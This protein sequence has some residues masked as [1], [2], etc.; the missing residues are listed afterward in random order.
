[1]KAI[2]ATE[3]TYALFNKFTIMKFSLLKSKTCMLL[4]FIYLE[5][6]NQDACDKVISPVL[7]TL[8]KETKKLEFKDDYMFQYEVDKLLDMLLTHG[9]NVQLT[10]VKNLHIKLNVHELTNRLSEK[11]EAN[12]YKLK[13]FYENLKTRIMA[14]GK[15]DQANNVLYQKYMDTFH[16]VEK[17][18]NESLANKKLAWRTVFD[19]Y[20]ANIITFQFKIRTLVALRHT[21]IFAAIND[22][23]LDYINK[24]IKL[25]GE[26]MGTHILPVL[27]QFQKQF[28]MEGLQ[29]KPLILGQFSWTYSEFFQ[30][31]IDQFYILIVL[32][33]ILEFDYKNPQKTL[34]E[35]Q[36]TKLYT[37]TISLLT[38]LSNSSA[39]SPV[40]NIQL[41]SNVF[42][43]TKEQSHPGYDIELL[44][45]VH[46]HFLTT[47]ENNKEIFESELKLEVSIA[48]KNADLLILQVENERANAKKTKKRRPPS[49]VS[50]IVEE[51][52]DSPDESYEEEFE[53]IPVNP[54]QE[55]MDNGLLMLKRKDYANAIEYFLKAKNEASWQNDNYQ[56]LN[57][58]DALTVAYSF[59]LQQD[60]DKILI[61]LNKRLQTMRPLSDDMQDELERLGY[62][63][64][65]RYS[66]LCVLY[67]DFLQAIEYEKISS[68]AHQII[69]EISEGKE[70]IYS[71]ICSI[72]R[73]IEIVDK[74][75]GELEKK[76][77]NER[78]LYH[79]KL[80]KELITCA[81][82]PSKYIPN[83]LI[84]IG[85]IKLA[86]YREKQ[87]DGTGVNQLSLLQIG[88]EFIQSQEKIAD[89]TQEEITALG[90]IKFSQLGRL[91]EDN[92]SGQSIFTRE[93]Q[94]FNQLQLIFKDISQ[95][96]S[97]TLVNDLEKTPVQQ[98]SVNLTESV[99]ALFLS[100][101]EASYEHYLVGS[102]AINILLAHW[103]QPP[104]Q[105]LDF[106]FV[107]TYV[108]NRA[109]LRLKF[110]QSTMRTNLF[111]GTLFGQK[112]DLLCLNP[113]N[114]WLMKSLLSR[115]FTIAALAVGYD[116]ATNQGLI[117]DPTG[118]GFEDLQE[119][120]IKTIG[121]PLFRLQ[122]DPTIA[123]AVIKYE[124]LGFKIDSTVTNAMFQLTT[125][126]P[127][128]KAHLN[129]LLTKL[130]Q[131]F[132]EFDVL[133]LLIKYKLLNT[134]FNTNHQSDEG[135]TLFELKKTISLTAPGLFINPCGFFS[136]STSTKNHAE[137]EVKT[138]S[139]T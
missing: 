121:N 53:D 113:E 101:N 5:S 132:N 84:A 65:E 117:I 126:K 61:T 73:K 34:L 98:I 9:E 46:A 28:N 57:V 31:F 80:G 124:L 56:Q 76:K 123:L 48:Q 63:V 23:D 114:N 129:A 13:W 54:I 130:L 27:S 60:L 47:E 7:M 26:L 43:N 134:L 94:L 11:C 64:D 106:D 127:L 6:G 19:Y 103:N 38:F 21:T 109:M 78:S 119:R 24:Y 89:Y 137:K 49:P 111:Y 72:K 33:D 95:H 85:R 120:C 118:S 71:L 79:S 44:K 75:N 2:L 69:Q 30:L 131:Q 55:N 87:N 67:Q 105:A 40:L 102:S 32:N 16:A 107:T 139:F 15:H 4:G 96:A 125:T 136:S 66:E 74:K 108:D 10:P 68:K 104:I 97:S 91:K 110:K 14:S 17:K 112:V 86:Q 93:K 81:G 42:H 82:D 77:D 20:N 36:I 62:V 92:N 83:E 45:T 128:P 58:I 116:A 18:F 51:I 37:V 90:K 22:N 1:M 12:F 39:N 100:L 99:K 115:H 52:K 59:I 8:I 41:N 70:T 35:E 133:K 138:L 135:Q 88:R 50:T 29:K 25:H 122:N 3:K